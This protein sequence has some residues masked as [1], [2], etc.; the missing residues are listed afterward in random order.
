LGTAVIARDDECGIA[1]GRL[2][3][4]AEQ[5]A[6]LQTQGATSSLLPQALSAMGKCC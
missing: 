3:S 1:L 2:A 4:I 5:A 6:E